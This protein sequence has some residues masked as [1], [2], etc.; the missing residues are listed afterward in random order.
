MRSCVTQTNQVVIADVE[1]LNL[2]S[3]DSDADTTDAGIQHTVLLTADSA[4]SISVPGSA[5]LVVAGADIADVITFDASGLTLAATDAGVTV[6]L[7][8]NTVGGTTT[9]TGSG[10]TDVLTGGSTQAIQCLAGWR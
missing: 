1:T 10:G 8:Y 2:S 5:G 4:T 6:D 9:I 7:T 3:V